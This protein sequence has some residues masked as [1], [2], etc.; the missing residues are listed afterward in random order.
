MAEANYSIKASIEANT[1]KFKSALDTAKRTAEKFKGTMEKLRTT[2]LTQTLGVKSAV[3]SAK[4]SLE[5]F[6]QKLMQS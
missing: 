1:K 2:R 3:E 6:D 4:A 5:S